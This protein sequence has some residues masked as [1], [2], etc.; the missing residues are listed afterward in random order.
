VRSLSFVLM[1]L[2]L[3]FSLSPSSE[4]ASALVDIATWIIEKLN[5]TILGYCVI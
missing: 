5:P 4:S 2:A 3:A 1:A